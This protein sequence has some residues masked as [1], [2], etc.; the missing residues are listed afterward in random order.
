M[1]REKNKLV[2]SREGEGD[3][4]KCKKGDKSGEQGRRDKN[5]SKRR[6]E[7]KKEKIRKKNKWRNCVCVLG[8]YRDLQNI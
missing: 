6:E 1:R 5:R 7:N 8:G 2:K 3:A 4:N